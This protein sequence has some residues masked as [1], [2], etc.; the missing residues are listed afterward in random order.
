MSQPVVLSLAL[1]FT[2]LLAHG[3]SHWWL[4]KRRSI[5]DTGG[6]ENTWAHVSLALSIWVAAALGLLW[7]WGAEERATAIATRLLDAGFN[8][9]GITFV[10]VRIVVGILLATVLMRLVRHLRDRLGTNWLA[11][12][13][14]DTAARESM[15]TLFGYAGMVIAVLA[16]LGFAGFNLTNL[17][18][19]AGALSVGIGFGLQNIVNN[20][21]SGLILL[22]ERPVRRGDY[23]RVGDVEGEVRKV[24]IRATEIETLDRVSVIVPNSELIA[25]PVHNWRLRDPYIRVVIRVGVAYGSDTELVTKT[26]R[27]IG[28]SHQHTLPDNTPGVPD[29]HVFFTDFGDSSLMFELRTFIRDVN[30]RGVVASDLRFAI[31]RAFRE[32]NITIPFPQRD[33]WMRNH[34]DI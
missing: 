34:V 23:V 18:I 1:V 13:Q 27:E 19:V 2:T 29:T 10:P 11:R 6:A 7:I 8:V 16:G 17:A 21:V 31:D 12:S 33:I 32:K 24:H 20:F 25:N 26:L 4:L 14:W 9:A 5:K 3:F 30:K 15:A 22:S 28:V